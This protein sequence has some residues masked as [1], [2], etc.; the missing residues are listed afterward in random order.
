MQRPAPSTACS[1][2][3]TRVHRDTHVS[4][5]V[6]TINE[7][8][9]S[10][11]SHNHTTLTNVVCTSQVCPTH[12]CPNRGYGQD[13]PRPDQRRCRLRGAGLKHQRLPG[14][15]S[16]GRRGACIAGVAPPFFFSSPVAG[17]LL[18]YAYSNPSPAKFHTFVAFQRFP[19]QNQSLYVILSLSLS[20]LPFGALEVPACW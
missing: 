8:L 19:N 7:L 5:I 15:K 2:T 14:Y 13:V 16:E 4:S 9:R 11:K 17:E 3:L 10:S 20:M 6:R 1:S 12:P 18:L